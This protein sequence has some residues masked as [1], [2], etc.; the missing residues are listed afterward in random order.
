MRD[1]IFV[2]LT[3]LLALA[4]VAECQDIPGLAECGLKTFREIGRNGTWS[5]KESPGCRVKTAVERRNGGI[6]VTTWVIADAGEG[7]TR[8]AFSAAMD[9]SEIGGKRALTRA[10]S[11]VLTRARRLQR[12][13]DSIIR[14]NDPLECRDHAIRSSVVD[15]ESGTETRRLVWLDD[16]GRH[17]VVEY[18]FGSMAATPTPPVDLFSGYY[19]PPNISI[20]LHQRRRR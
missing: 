7:W 6:F 8:T 11:D 16:D 14:V 3:A 15:E 5:G 10:G 19:L 13:L 4:S 17:A 9:Q 20:D 18:A 12:C 2:L 1:R